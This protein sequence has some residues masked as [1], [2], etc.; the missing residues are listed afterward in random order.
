M[1]RAQTF[2]NAMYIGGQP[3][4]RG[5]GPAAALSALRGTLLRT[6]LVSGVSFAVGGLLIYSVRSRYS[7]PDAWGRG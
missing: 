7:I 1:P 5:D 6:C 3:L 2:S 4:I